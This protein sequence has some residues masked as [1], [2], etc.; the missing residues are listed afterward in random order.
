[1]L[2]YRGWWFFVTVVFVLA[3]SLWTTTSSVSLLCLTLLLWFLGNWLVFQVR[4]H[5]IHGRLH[6]ARDLSD[7]QGPVQSL[8]VGRTFR[9]RVRLAAD[10]PAA[11]PFVRIQ[12]RVPFGV[13]RIAGMIHA[14]GPL[15]AQTPLEIQYHVHCQAPGRVRFEGLTVQVADMQGF[16]YHKW[17]IQGVQHYRVLP[18]LADARGHFPTKKRHNLLPLIGAHRHKRPGSGSELL[19]LR[20]Y[21]PGDPPKMIA[22]KPSARR[23]RLMTKE[24]ESEVPI[25][26]TLFVDTSASVRVG[27]PGHNALARLVEIVAALAQANSAARDLT[28]LCLFDERETSYVK[29]ARTPRHILQLFNLLAEVAALTPTTGEVAV[30]R[31]LPLA[32]GLCEEVYPQLLQADVNYY[33]WWLPLWAPQSASTLRRP[34]VSRRAWLPNLEKRLA[35]WSAAIYQNTLARINIAE[36]KFSRWRKQVAAILAARYRLGAGAL[37]NLLEDDERFVLLMQHFL[38]EH[39]VPFDLPLYGPEQQYL[40]AAPEK[41][42][43]LAG[44]LRRAVGRGRDNELFVL[45]ADLLELTDRLEPLLAA[46]KMAVARH[47]AVMVLCPWPPGVPPPDRSTREA[48]KREAKFKSALSDLVRGN[49]A[50]DVLHL[51]LRHTT[52]QRMHDAYNRVQRTFARVGVPVL[53]ARHDEA[54]KLVLRRLERLRVLERGVR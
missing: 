32:Y 19:D 25:R 53:C 15:S 40:F 50:P 38:I 43:V 14:E 35:Y 21:M 13:K 24:F 4:T 31:L 7:D 8:W 49:R 33:P 36:W 34:P 30:N 18:A 45:M 46:V 39:Q 1:M 26:C 5:R 3:V 16:F 23:D 51:V 41:I 29:P 28:G 44:A 22:W 2:T 11:L 54:V 6:T 9:V 47:H 27:L 52:M 12:E 10:G 37:P 42:G 20:D 48:D 17:F